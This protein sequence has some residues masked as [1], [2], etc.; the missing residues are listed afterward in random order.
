MVVQVAGKAK[1]A[2]AAVAAVVADSQKPAAAVVQGG[3]QK[4]FLGREQRTDR[5]WSKEWSCGLQAFEAERMTFL[6]RDITMCCSL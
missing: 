4:G 5:P 1:A 6:L 3:L 2:A